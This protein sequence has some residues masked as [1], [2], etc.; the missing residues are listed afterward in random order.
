MKRATDEGGRAIV[1]PFRVTGF[2][3][4]ATVLEGLDYVADHQGLIPHSEV[5]R[6]IEHEIDALEA[7]PFRAALP[8][9]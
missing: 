9:G 7:S 3:P 2:G 4:Y 6:W 5:T 8:P 1:I